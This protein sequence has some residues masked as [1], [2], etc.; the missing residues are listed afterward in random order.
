MSDTSLHSSARRRLVA[1]TLVA[2]AALGFLAT[3][4]LTTAVPAAADVSGRTVVTD[5]SALRAELLN[6]A[7]TVERGRAAVAEASATVAEAK[8][9][10]FDLGTITI[11]TSGLARVLNALSD[12]EAVGSARS[13][14]TANAL[15][16]S[17]ITTASIAELRGRLDA[18]IAQKQAE[19]AAA[20]EAAAQA[21]ALAA[22]NTPDGARSVAAT[23][24]ASEFGW[25]GDQFSCLD[26]LWTKESGWDYQAYNPSGA[27]GIPQALPG[28]KMSSAGADWQSNA[29][30]QIRW[31]LGYIASVYGSPC[32]AWGH[33]QSVNWY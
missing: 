12:K 31:G 17:E 23:I 16:E 13:I 25:G 2:G 7:A 29:T 32:S 6:S 20:A 27:T 1:I 28:D 14:L 18:A 30:T 24:A 33:S 11:D 21:A 10:G 8:A 5:R 26:S 4:G 3:A 15:V 19:E 22:A 9:S